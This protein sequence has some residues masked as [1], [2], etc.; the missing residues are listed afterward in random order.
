MQDFYL[1]L[2]C[3]EFDVILDKTCASI[4]EYKKLKQAIITQAV[5]KDMR[6]NRPMKE[7]GI[8]WFDAVPEDLEISKIKYTVSLMKNRY[9]PQMMS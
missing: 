4:E 6:G 1:D 5:T 2:E 3:A 8:I 7:N 9:C